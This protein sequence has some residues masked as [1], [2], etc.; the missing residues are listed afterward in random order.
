M[1]H[2]KRISEGHCAIFGK[3]PSDHRTMDSIW[4]HRIHNE[5]SGMARTDNRGSDAWN[6]FN[7]NPGRGGSAHAQS[8]HKLLSDM[9]RVQDFN[10]AGTGTGMNSTAILGQQAPSP[11][12]TSLGQSGQ[13]WSRSYLD[14]T[15]ASLAASRRLVER[16][17][18]GRPF[19]PCG[20]LQQV[21]TASRCDNDKL[22]ESSRQTFKVTR[23]AE[24]FE[25]HGARSKRAAVGLAWRYT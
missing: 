5:Q 21:L 23:S 14:T 17:A 10:W 15:S 19:L 25:A 8:S 11:M 4:R 18:F 2:A 12:E 6:T 20:D 7:W 13:A 1:P 24:K 9:K 22:A 3:E 16:D